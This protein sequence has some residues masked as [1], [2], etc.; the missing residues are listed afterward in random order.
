[1]NRNGF[2]SRIWGPCAWLFLHCVS[3]NYDP[4]RK[5]GTRRFFLSLKD[6]LPCGTCRDNY[7][8]LLKGAFKP[9]DATFA[10]RDALVEWLFHV[11]N[12]INK[13][14]GKT[15]TFSDD[16]AGLRA[17]RRF[18]EQFRAKCDETKGSKASGAKGSKTRGAVR[19]VGCVKA[20]RNGTR[21]R[22]VLMVRPVEAKTHSLRICNK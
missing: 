16:A 8:E 12:A 9:T 19:E 15:L 17:M 14:T 2:Q 21:Y 6:V 4:V 18:Y 11:H 1:M 22:C 10:S 7:A 13:R 3:L 20:K 5:V